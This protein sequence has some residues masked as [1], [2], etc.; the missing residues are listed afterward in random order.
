MERERLGVSHV[1]KGSKKG[2]EENRCVK[3]GVKIKKRISKERKW[4]EE[5]RKKRPR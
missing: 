5:I 1:C 3:K 4:D 2:R